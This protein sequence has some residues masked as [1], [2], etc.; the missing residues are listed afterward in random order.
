MSESE[1]HFSNLKYRPEIDGLRALA[2]IPVILFHAGF[3]AVRGGFVGVD[4]FFVI[5]GY[6]ITSIILI[7]LEEEKFSIVKFY[8]RRARRIL[9]ALFFILFTC[10]PAAWILLPS[11]ELLSFSKSM[12]AVTLF[13]SN[14]YF[15]NDG[16][17]FET[18]AELKPLLHT[19]SLAVEEQ[20]YVLFPILLSILWKVGKNKILIIFAIIAILSLAF[21]EWAT[22]FKPGVSFFL[23]P[24]RSWELLI[25]ALTAYYLVY[26][27]RASFPIYLVELGGWLGLI[28]IVYPVFTYTSK[29]PFPGIHALAPTVGAALII[30]FAAKQTTVGKF[31]G[32]KVLVG[33]GLVS[34]SAYLWH[35]PILTFAKYLNPELMIFPKIILI[36][37]IFL[38]S[39]LSWK[40]IE[41]PF[42]VKAGFS[43]KTV[44]TISFVGSTLFV[45]IGL[46]S[47]Q[48]DFHREAVMA[49]ELTQNP[50][51]YTSN[52]NERKFIK[53]R[54][55]YEQ[56]NP[57]I[58][59]LGSSRIMQLGN[60]IADSKVL[61][62]AVSGASLEDDIAIW[63]LVSKKFNPDIVLVSA[64][65]WLFNANSGQQ[66]WE[67]LSSDYE[68][69]LSKL[70]PQVK[71]AKHLLPTKLWGNDFFSEIYNDVNIS[72]IA[73]K[74]DHPS[75]LDKI[76][77]DG[78][79]VYNLSYANQSLSEV[80]RGVSA[81]L[82][83]AMSEYS[84][85]QQAHDLFEKFIL[86]ISERHNVVIVLVPYHPKLYE[87]MKNKDEKFLNIEDA[88]RD[89]SSKLNVKIIGSYDP[90]KFGCNEGDF[91]DGMHPKD[92]CIKKIIH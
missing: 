9:P 19:W 81:F 54:I 38:V 52:I 90:A 31:I 48:I 6:L 32:N 77:Q 56:N 22:I 59:V 43:R 47:S 4:V 11:Y 14:F 50:A 12:V 74:D 68:A 17:Y 44:F 28:L 66:R 58:I 45:L 37:V 78:S 18:A 16:G 29:T 92:S 67:A 24:S 69:A 71:S 39:A 21:S 36:L 64:D 27:K 87:L 7:E 8:E 33:I 88:F 3:E 62:L 46:Y 1:F 76:R 73:A 86:S 72:Q 82:S 57:N 49:R 40:F 35:Q 5:S 2:I 10:I 26:K 30:V 83:Y 61:N 41:S 23:L 25:G 65:P 34:Y 85:S 89:I 55:E 53:L 79:H 91:F 75:L 15:W 42:R 51:V 80:E 60:N 70:D 63:H 84:D 20:F 13:I